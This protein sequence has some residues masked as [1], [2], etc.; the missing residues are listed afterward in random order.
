MSIPR[1][2]S[3]PALVGIVGPIV[4]IVVDLSASLSIPGYSPI[5]DTVSNLAL[6]PIG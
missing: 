5:R 6:I 3:A 4:M 1:V 2:N